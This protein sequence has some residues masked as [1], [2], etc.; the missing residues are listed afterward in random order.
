MADFIAHNSRWRVALILLGTV[1]FA[2]LGLWM[3]GAFGEVPSSRRHSAGYMV[4][5]GWLCILFFGFCAAAIGKKF[6]DSRPQLQIGPLGIVWSPWSDDVIPWSEIRTVTTWSH[7]GQKAIV[8]HLNNPDRF[9]AR[10]L[11]A[12]LARANQK[13]TGGHISISLIGTNRSHD[14]AMSAIARFRT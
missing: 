12:K 14:D 1:G 4:G 5:V 7:K 3:V 6:F 8:L 2:A 13:L 11:M 9:P 10:G